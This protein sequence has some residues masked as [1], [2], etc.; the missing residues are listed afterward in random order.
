LNLKNKAIMKKA[1]IIVACS[2]FALAVTSAFTLKPKALETDKQGYFI[3]A[4]GTVC[5]D[6]GIMCST[7]G[8]VRCTTGIHGVQKLFELQL[9]GTCA[10][11]LFADPD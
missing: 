1:Q 8:A 6:S 7:T 11:P 9:N 2:A 3:P 4:D 5:Q 10:V